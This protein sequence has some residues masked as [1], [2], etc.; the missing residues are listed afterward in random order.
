VAHEWGTMT[1]VQGSDGAS[2]VGLHRDEEALPAFVQGRACQRQPCR[3]ESNKCLEFRPDPAYDLGV[4]QALETP[5]IYFYSTGP[6]A[7]EVHVGFPH[8][9]I[10]QW[11]PEPIAFTPRAPIVV[12]DVKQIGG[13]SMT[14]NV[15]VL[16]PTDSAPALAPA[17]PGS[18]WNPAREV[19]SNFIEASIGGERQF[20]KFIFYRGV[21]QFE[22]PFKVRSLSD[23]RGLLLTNHSSSPIPAAF[24]LRFESGQGEIKKIGAIGANQSLEVRDVPLI[25]PSSPSSES[26]RQLASSMIGEALVQADLYDDEARAL[27]DTWKRSYFGTP[28]LKILYIMPRAWADEYLPMR[29]SPAP[30]E[31][32]RAFV[33][34]IEVLTAQEESALLAQVRLSMSTHAAFPVESMGRMAEPKLRR[35]F[36]LT[37]DPKEREYIGE[38]IAKLP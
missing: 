29:M 10:S 22:T 18:I 25:T 24:L 17:P 14:W 15:T 13:G 20:E 7:I 21:G 16:P 4:V 8:G 38:L 9:L 19:K 30:R 23:G 11:Y 35:V 32:V 27:L 3:C 33:G 34:R 28:G 6:H 37:T 5:V 1:S 2:M 31:L 36:R 26:Y 12:G